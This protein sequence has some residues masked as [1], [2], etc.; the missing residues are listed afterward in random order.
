MRKGTK[1]L[2]NVLDKEYALKI[3]PKITSGKIN[4][5]FNDGK[6]GELNEIP[7]PLNKLI[8][9]NKFTFFIIFL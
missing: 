9:A 5:E 1:E 6:K 2:N 3:Q 4:L 8:K 7:I